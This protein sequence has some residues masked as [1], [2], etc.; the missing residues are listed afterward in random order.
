[1]RILG[2]SIYDTICEDYE[3]ILI[4]KNYLENN[5]SPLNSFYSL[6]NQSEF[7]CFYCLYGE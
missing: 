3:K 6:G 2:A 7:S 1:M 5:T 4:E